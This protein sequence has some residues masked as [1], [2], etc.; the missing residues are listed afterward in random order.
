MARGI[1]VEINS[2]GAQAIL[3]SSEVAEKLEDMGKAITKAANDEAPEHGYTE[4]EPFAM[5][6][7]TSDRAFVNVYTRTNLGKAM[8][9]KHSTLTQAMD[10]GRRA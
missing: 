9:A 6:S 7:G 2:S 3:K 1:R 8:Q 4:Q 10:A 5:E